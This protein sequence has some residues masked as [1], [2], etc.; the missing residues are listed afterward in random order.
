MVVQ[1]MMILVQ[2]WSGAGVGV[3]MLRGTGFPYLVS[4][5]LG[6]LVSKP[7][8]FNVS[9]TPYYQKSIS[10]FLEDGDPKTKIFMKI[11]NA[12]STCFDPAFPTIFKLWIF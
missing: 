1:E 5:F 10:C 4:K 2:G 8:S 6:F 9:M 7:R 11:L 12:S 3:G